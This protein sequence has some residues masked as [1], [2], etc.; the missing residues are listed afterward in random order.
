MAV[1]WC[2]DQLVIKTTS[3]TSQFG[4]YSL[5]LKETWVTNIWKQIIKMVQK[6]WQFC[7]ITDI[8]ITFQTV[9]FYFAKN[10][11][12]QFGSSCNQIISYSSVNKNNV[13][14]N[15]IKLGLQ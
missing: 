5:G 8:V 6:Q 1:L 7:H 14:L 13:L 11:D 12:E 2:I 15:V 9:I 10:L 4:L 3:N